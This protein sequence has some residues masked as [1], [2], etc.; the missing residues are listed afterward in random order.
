L[1]PVNY[2]GIKEKKQPFE[3]RI[4][5]LLNWPLAIRLWSLA[6]GRNLAKQISINAK[7]LS[8]GSKP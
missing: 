1:S 6:E 3:K 2:I 4:V 5:F 8:K 7:D